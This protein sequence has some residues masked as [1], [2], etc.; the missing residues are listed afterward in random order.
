[1]ATW[2][3]YVLHFYAATHGQWLRDRAQSVIA[4][5]LPLFVTEWGT[6]EATGGAVDEA[7]TRAWIALRATSHQ[8]G[9]LVAKRQGR[10]VRRAAAAREPDRPLDG[11]RA[12]ALGR[13]GQNT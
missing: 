9:Q 4:T 12:H 13:A 1:M 3:T 10:V 6:C 11:S 7:E 8:L 2:R 5:G